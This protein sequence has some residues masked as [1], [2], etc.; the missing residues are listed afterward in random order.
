VRRFAARVCLVAGLGIFL[1]ALPVFAD[2]LVLSR[3]AP[4]NTAVAAVSVRDAKPAADQA[5][6]PDAPAHDDR[7]SASE[8]LMLVAGLTVIGLVTLWRS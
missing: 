3:T 1:P 7:S 8:L 6:A 5:A 2:V 4:A